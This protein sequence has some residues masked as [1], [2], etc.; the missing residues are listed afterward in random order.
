MKKLIKLLSLLTD[1]GLFKKPLST[2]IRENI[3]KDILSVDGSKWFHPK[4]PNRKTCSFWGT[5]E[6][7]DG[8]IVYKYGD[9]DLS[10]TRQK[11]HL[12]S[13]DGMNGEIK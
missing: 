4:L 8:E 1:W 13:A 7:V 10:L 5:T 11:T 2:K 6:I 3:V 9:V 12:L